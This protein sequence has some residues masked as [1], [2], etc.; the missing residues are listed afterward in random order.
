VT[1]APSQDPAAQIRATLAAAYTELIA[2]SKVAVGE[3]G[4][5][6]LGVAAAVDLAVESLIP[7]APDR[8]LASSSCREAL[9][10]LEKTRTYAQGGNIAKLL[11]PARAKIEA[12]LSALES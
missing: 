9:S 4:K 6:L 10:L 8:A 7:P 2:A 1:N 11:D 12:M 5:T 3:D